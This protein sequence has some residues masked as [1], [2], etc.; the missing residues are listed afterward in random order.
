MSLLLKAYSKT[1]CSLI[2]KLT[3]TY[4]HL[5]LLLR[6]V[7]DVSAL[8]RQS[9]KPSYSFKC[10]TGFPDISFKCQIKI[11]VYIFP[12]HIFQPSFHVKRDKNWN[13]HVNPIDNLKMF[14]LFPHTFNVL[15]HLPHSCLLCKCGWVAKYLSSKSVLR[16]QMTG[17]S[18]GYRGE[19]LLPGSCTF[20]FQILHL[21]PWLAPNW[22]QV[23]MPCSSLWCLSPLQFLMLF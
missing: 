5:Y 12:H 2:W 13:V 1:S 22:R 8:Y 3:S 15:N 6:G 10:G 11:L 14:W 23:L 16:L 19:T 9:L 17:R 18:T 20:S 4:L 21:S 7:V